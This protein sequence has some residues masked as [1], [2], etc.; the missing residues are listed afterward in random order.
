MAK[1]V[2]IDP[3]T[4]TYGIIGLE[5]GKV[6]LD[7]SFPTKN[8]VNQPEL[9]LDTLKSIG[10]IDLLVAPSGMGVPM[11]KIEDL[12][13]NYLFEMTLEKK[14]EGKITAISKVAKLLKEAG[15]RGY[16]IPGVKHLPT[17]PDYRK[18]NKI[19]LGTADKVC[20]A[21]LGIYDQSQK[22]SIPYNE[23]SFILIEMGSGF[24]AILGIENGQIVDG[25]GG[26]LGGIGFL[27]CGALDGELAYLFGEIK[28][29]F[30]YQGGAAYIAGYK[31]L[32]FEEFEILSKQDDK[33]RMA[34]EAFLDGIIKNV[35]A[36]NYSVKKPREILLSGKLSHFDDIKNRLSTKISEIAPIRRVKGLSN[37]KIAKEAAQGAA[38]IADGL[39]GG[40]FKELLE[41]SRLKEAKGSNLDLIYF[42]HIDE[43]KK[44]Y[45]RD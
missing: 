37:V 12:N 28:K 43:I 24:N 39:I 41:V 30:L 14:I 34:Y 45:C 6:I 26:T 36:I 13:D 4:K 5:N 33:F 29:Q 3:G 10:E 38:I 8:I 9:I 40:Q 32:S 35:A 23:T 7:T 11:V 19:D 18:V 20:S 42:K 22:L 17:V 44:E 21:I 27:S 2:G 25:I 31:D 1:V 16:F 15:Y